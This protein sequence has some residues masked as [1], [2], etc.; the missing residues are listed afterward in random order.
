M[1]RVADLFWFAS[2]FSSPA[3]AG[4]VSAQRTEETRRVRRQAG[5]PLTILHMVPFPRFAGGEKTLTYSLCGSFPCKN[6]RGLK[7]PEGKR[8]Q[9]SV[10]FRRDD[11]LLVR[12]PQTRQVRRVGLAV[13][14]IG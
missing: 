13:L 5:A 9:D 10:F 2:H 14:D 3:S 11:D 6:G 4:D 8:L 12:K 7:R 1:R